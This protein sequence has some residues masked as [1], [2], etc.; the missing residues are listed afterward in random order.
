[1][2]IYLFI[3]YDLKEK[4]THVKYEFKHEEQRSIVTQQQIHSE[5]NKERIFCIYS[6]AV[7]YSR[8]STGNRITGLKG[9]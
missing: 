6:R 1:M 2:K 5:Y 8:S 9:L 7:K 4:C 3:Y